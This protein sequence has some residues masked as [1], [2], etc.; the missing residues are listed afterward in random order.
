MVPTMSIPP[1]FG[2]GR[3]V[4][5]DG[6]DDLEADIRVPTRLTRFAPG[7]ADLLRGLVRARDGRGDLD[8]VQAAAQLF[9]PWRR[10]RAP[11]P[12]QSRENLDRVAPLGGRAYLDV[13][14]HGLDR[15]ALCPD[16]GQA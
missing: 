5:L 14:V 3:D 4:Q 11:G 15:D 1:I 7:P 6:H 16:R 10:A 8:R 2:L 13:A 9:R 12:E